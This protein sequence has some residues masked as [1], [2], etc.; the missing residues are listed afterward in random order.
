MYVTY[1][2]S[3]THCCFNL[4]SVFVRSVVASV[5]GDSPGFILFVSPI[6]G[7]SRDNK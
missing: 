4:W 7:A 3:L 6:Y 1:L 2:I 5:I